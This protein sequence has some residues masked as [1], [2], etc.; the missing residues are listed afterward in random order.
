[1]RTI[2]LSLIMAAALASAPAHAAALEEASIRNGET[3]DISPFSFYALY[4]T[5]VT[6]AGARLVDQDG[7][8]SDIPLGIVQRGRL[9]SFDL[10][11][12]IPH[13]YRLEWRVR[14]ALG[15]ESRHHVSFLV[16]GCKDLRAV[17]PAAPAS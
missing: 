9:V 5:D 8:A 14:D 15:L 17:K 6:L 11:V 7:K 13:G 10:P 16:R 4:G 3:F 12:L 2:L 1:M